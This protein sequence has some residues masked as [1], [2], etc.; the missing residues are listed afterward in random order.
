MSVPVEYNICNREKTGI[1]RQVRLRKLSWRFMVSG[2]GTSESRLHLDGFY[3]SIAELEIMSL[4]ALEA[5][6]LQ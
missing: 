1:A 3:S 4:V 6:I 5:Q 2:D